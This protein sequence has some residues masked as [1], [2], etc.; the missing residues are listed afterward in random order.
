MV[1]MELIWWKWICIGIDKTAKGMGTDMVNGTDTVNG[2]DMVNGTYTVNGADMV[3]GTYMVNGTD[4]VN[5]IYSL[6]MEQHK[7]MEFSKQI[8]YTYY[9]CIVLV[10]VCLVW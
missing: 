2:T 4:M 10:F 3:N 8:T 9:I 6:N 1:K 5:R 7:K